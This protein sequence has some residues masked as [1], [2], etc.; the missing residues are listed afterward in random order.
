MQAAFDTNNKKTG[1]EVMHGADND[2]L[3]AKAQHGSPDMLSKMEAAKHQWIESIEA[4]HQCGQHH[5]ANQS[6]A[7][8]RQ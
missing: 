5:E 2:D 7:P 3:L 4:A 6:A 8:P 1:E